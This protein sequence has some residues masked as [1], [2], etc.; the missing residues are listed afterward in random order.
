MKAYT[1][2][3]NGDKILTLPTS[4]KTFELSQLQQIVGGYI[5]II[6][7]RKRERLMVL[8]E[9]GKLDGLPRNDKATELWEEEYGEGTDIIVGNVLI[10]EPS[11][12]E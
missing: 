1:L 3:T 4:G 7:L 6:P 5:E 12:I 9:E 10:C 11:M 8:N 2:M